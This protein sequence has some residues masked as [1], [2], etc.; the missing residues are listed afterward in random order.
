MSVASPRGRMPDFLLVGAT[1]SGAETLM[2]WLGQHPQIVTSPIRETNYFASKDLGTQGV[3]DT[4]LLSRPRLNADGTFQRADVARVVGRQDYERC[5]QTAHKP[6]ALRV[7][8]ASPAYGFYPKAARRIAE[9]IPHCKIVAVLRDPVERVLAHHAAFEEQGREH[10]SLEGALEREEQ[11]LAAGWSYHWSY[12]GMSRYPASLARYLAQFALPQIHL[13][14]AEDLR[15]PERGPVAWQSLLKFL[16]VDAGVP[17]PP[18]LARLDG[19][20]HPPAA[21]GSTGVAGVTRRAL[22][23]HLRVEAR[24]YREVFSEATFRRSTLRDLARG[25]FSREG[26]GVRRQANDGGQ[27]AGKPPDDGAVFQH[28]LLTDDPVRGPL[29]HRKVSHNH[30]ACPRVHPEGGMRFLKDEVFSFDGFF[31]AFFESLVAEH[32]GMSTVQL[33]LE[34]SGRFFI[35]VFRLAQGRAPQ[36]VTSVQSER[37]PGESPFVLAL[38]L[39]VAN[40]LGS[41]LVFNLACLSKEGWFAGGSW[42]TTATPRRPVQLAI[43]ACTY[44][45]REFIERTVRRIADYERLPHRDYVITVVDNASELPDDLFPYAHVQIVRQGNVG[46]A[47]G[48]ARGIIEGLDAQGSKRPTH[49]LLMDDDIELEPDMVLRAMNWLRH[50]KIDQ[51]IGGGMLDLYRPTYL[52]EMGATIGQPKVFSITP[53]LP[54]LELAPAGSLDRLGKLPPPHYNAWWFVTVSRE[55]VERHGLPLPCFIRGDDKEFGFRMLKRGVPTLSVPGI[56]VWHVPFYAKTN[57]WLY[58]Y[59]TYNDILICSLRFPHLTGEVLANALLRQ[60]KT[61][62]DRLEYDQATMRVLGL[63]HFLL[64]PEWLLN[65]DCEERFR[66]IMLASKP[67]EA[68]HRKDVEPVNFNTHYWPKSLL[69][70]SWRR[71]I[72]NGHLPLRWRKPLHTTGGLPHKVIR[73]SDW[74]WSDV[75]YFDE[76]GVKHALVPGIYVYQKRPEVYYNLLRRAKVGVA[77]LRREWSQRAAAFR[78]CDGELTSPE[79]WRRYLRFDAPEGEVAQPEVTTG[80]PEEPLVPEL[81]L[82]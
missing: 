42:R 66:E 19:V 33:R 5:F 15:N 8:E 51:C 38:D 73:I 14:R 76:I 43:L 24:F 13:V 1:F 20:H 52:H 72:H 78:E 37:R 45:K 71:L 26:P 69:D 62:L 35:E 65:T 49:F 12:L 46:G 75:T 28:I 7:G 17:P 53:C 16:G 11:R 25:E 2:D 36:L 3:L 18:E 23:D 70:R 59:N 22:S 27:T 74:G 80:E 31:N 4:A 60:I 30:G 44:K 61:Y 21:T 77:R 48:A 63:E 6:G 41:R 82:G 57:A 54:G 81:V 9:E 10:L 34:F 47:G 50:T 58:Y 68:E 67:L 55:A 29:Y 39:S 40:P 64:G 32:T 79:F 56:A